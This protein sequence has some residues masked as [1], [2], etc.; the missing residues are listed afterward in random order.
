M[1]H[2]VQYNFILTTTSDVQYLVQSFWY[3]LPSW[4]RVF[5]TSTWL[6]TDLQT[7]TPKNL[8]SIYAEMYPKSSR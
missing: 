8:F 1:Y 4:F 7:G 5:G 2:R 3:Q 6:N